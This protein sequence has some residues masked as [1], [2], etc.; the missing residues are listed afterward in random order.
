MTGYQD[1]SEF[2]RAV[3]IGAREMGQDIYEVAMKFGFSCTI[4]S[5]V[6]SEYQECDKTSNL[7]H[8]CGREK[9]MQERDQRRLTRIIWRDRRATFCKLLQIL[10]LGYQQA[11]PCE[12]LNETSSI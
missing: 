3:I 6:Y 12:P 8:H 2:E 10:M 4:T 9:I 11:S 1:L 7:R 5:R